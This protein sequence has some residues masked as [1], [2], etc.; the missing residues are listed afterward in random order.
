MGNS[1]EELE[2]LG[3]VERKEVI[4][5]DKMIDEGCPNIEPLPEINLDKA[6]PILTDD[7]PIVEHEVSETKILGVE[8]VEKIKKYPTIKKKSDVVYHY[9]LM[10]VRP[11]L[12]TQN[13]RLTRKRY[14]G[15][16][17]EDYLKQLEPNGLAEKYLEFYNAHPFYKEVCGGAKHHH[18]WMGGLED[19]VREM[20]GIGLDL[21]DLYTGDFT[22]SRSDVIITCFLHDFN[23]IWIYKYLTDEERA[24]NPKRYKEK[25]VF[26]FVD[27]VNNILDGYSQILLELSRYGITPTN[28]QWSA[29]LFHEG[30]Y[31]SANFDYNGRTHTGDTVMHCNH[32]APFMHI[33]DIYSSMILGR[34][35]V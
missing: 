34:T 12:K 21:M 14:A 5:G 28:E 4:N 18:W 33:L 17:I 26:S 20:I 7:L 16:S 3:V 22:F 6:A 32:L 23:K 10:T 35:L 25:Q 8:I 27:G 31:A 19:H 2:K 30:G 15:T 13:A 29:V 24:R 9:D 11:Y 1:M